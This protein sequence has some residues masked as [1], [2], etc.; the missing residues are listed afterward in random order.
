M[1]QLSPLSHQLLALNAAFYEQTA[2]SFSDSRDY[3]WA[4]WEKIIPLLPN[5]PQSELHCLDLGCGNAR[6]AEFLAQHI[7]S[8]QILKYTG[9]DNSSNL[10]NLAKD[11]LNQKVLSNLSLPLHLQTSFQLDLLDLSDLAAIKKYLAA[12]PKS[13]LITLFGVLH[14]LPEVS[15]RQQLLETL[16]SHL[17]P[18][19]FLI[20]SLW[21][22]MKDHRLAGRVLPNADFPV[23]ISPQQL[24]SGDYLLDWQ[25]DQ[26]SPHAHLRFCHHF[27]DAEVDQLVKSL[28]TQ[29]QI[30]LAARWQ[31]D[32]PQNNPLNCY[33][34]FQK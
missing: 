1:P 26:I 33:L 24:E 34:V 3:F 32:G 7:S 16:I 13:E 30:R 22:F 6:F 18:Q 31:A 21:Q 10:L 27:S 23:H 12:Q 14:H 17:T 28:T 5:F 25:R 20:V 8:H 2:E 29:T 11:R 15:F 4:G 9:T 19:G